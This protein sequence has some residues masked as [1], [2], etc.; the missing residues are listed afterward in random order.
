MPITQDEEGSLIRSIIISSAAVATMMLAAAPTEAQRWNDR[1]WRTIATKEV[2]G[3][4]TDNVY[5]PGFMRQSE[6]RI[7]VRRAPLR[8]RDF[9]IRFAN[10]GRQ[11]VGTRTVIGA[12]SCTRAVDLRGNRRDIERIRL[13]YE[14]FLRHAVRPIVRVQIR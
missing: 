9:Q 13:R 11:D 14:P 1:G 8:L 6:V 4:D 3:R 7:C 5:L 12:D 2:S 10:G